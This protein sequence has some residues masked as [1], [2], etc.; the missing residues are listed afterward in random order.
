MY[1]MS[2]GNLVINPPVEMVYTMPSMSRNFPIG[3][4]HMLVLRSAM[5][6]YKLNKGRVITS[7]DSPESDGEGISYGRMFSMAMC[8]PIVGHA[9]VTNGMLSVCESV[10]AD[11]HQ[12]QIADA[13]SKTNLGSLK[14]LVGDDPTQVYPLLP[15]SDLLRRASEVYRETGP[16]C[17]YNNQAVTEAM[18]HSSDNS[19]WQSLYPLLEDVECHYGL[20]GLIHDNTVISL[21]QAAGDDIEP[22]LEQRNPKKEHEGFVDPV[23]TPQSKSS[24][25]VRALVFGTSKRI[26][27]RRTI[28]I[29]TKILS[30]LR[31]PR[32]IEA[33][34]WIVR[35]MGFCTTASESEVRSM[36]AEWKKYHE[37]NM[38]TVHV[39]ESTKVFVVS[40][41]TGV[42]LRH[43]RWKVASK[44]FVFEGPLVDSMTVHKSDTMRFAGLSFPDRVTEPEQYF[45]AAVLTIT[46]GAWTADPRLNLGLQMLRQ[47]MSTTPIKGDATITAMGGNKALVITP[48]MDATMQHST[49][50]CEISTPG[51]YVVTAFI[52]RYLNTED[53]CTVSKEFA[54]SGA[55]SWS[56]YINYPLPRDPG[57]IRVGTVLKDQ[58]WWAPAIEGTVVNLNMSKA[59]NSIAVVYVASTRLEVGDK[60]GT[61]HGLKF[62]VGEKISYGSTTR[63][64]HEL[65]CAD[66]NVITVGQ[67]IPENEMPSIV[68]PVTGRE[69]KPNLLLS[70]KNITRGLGGQI[71]EMAAVTNMFSSVHAFRNMEESVATEVIPFEDQKKVEPKLPNGYVVV[72][73]KRLRFTDTTG[74]KRTV[75]ATYGIMRVLQLRHIAA[76]KHHYPSTNF[77]SITIPKGRYRQGTPRLGEGEL[78]AMMMQNTPSNVRDSIISSDMCIVPKC[79]VCNRLTITCDCP[80]PKPAAIE[81]QTRYSLVMLAVFSDVAMMNSPNS[82]PISMEFITRT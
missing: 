36:V 32:S 57:N 72:N 25:K 30:V 73:G 45:N 33:K 64:G 27:T 61:M 75:R 9:V 41:A 21:G 65:T 77:V 12:T 46:F 80:R 70:T 39:F 28:D 26:M 42:V 54:E 19:F 71:R 62:T 52:N 81:V 8:P 24:G 22:N 51:K 16:L 44:R 82:T 56:G 10:Y 43:M 11:V 58:W 34:L 55:F 20:Y 76:L 4:E 68:D 14:W 37:I 59:G 35:C 5:K 47:A 50:E 48:F 23:F 6:Q 53:A 63:T 74:T 2:T 40:V 18:N 69:F 31:F 7:S 78:L 49:N 67:I 38:P 66:T 3:I 13:V 79:S 15:E 60:L 29:A 17:A 1:T